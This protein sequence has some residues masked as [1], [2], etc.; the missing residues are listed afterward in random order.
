[1]EWAK[2]ATG[3]L[4]KEGVERFPQLTIAGNQTR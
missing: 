4:T 2:S 3:D 1:M